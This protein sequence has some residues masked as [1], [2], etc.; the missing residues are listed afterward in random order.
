MRWLLATLFALTALLV[1]QAAVAEERILSFDSQVAIG[2]DGTLD[3]TET[4]HV[5]VENVAINHGIYRDFPTRY[6]APRGRRVKVGFTL[7][8]TLLDGQSEPNKVETLTN[9]VRIRIG[10]ADRIVPRG[11]HLYTIRYRA[12]RMIGRF[13]GYDELYWN[14]TGNDWNFPIDRATATITLPSPARF[15]QRAAYT[16]RQGSTEQAARVISEEPGS[17]RFITTRPLYPQEGLTVAAAFPKGVVAEPSESTRLG[18]FLSDWGPPLAGAAGL[19]GILG[20][21]F[22]AWRMAGRDPRPGTVV[23]LFSPPDDL[24]PAAMRYVLIQNLDNRGFAAALVDAAVK[25]HV[26]LV[27]EDGGWFGGDKRRIERFVY[28]ETQP[29]PATEQAFLNTLVSP[30]ESL[31]MEQKNH[32]TFSAA[33][34]ALG[35]R[36]GEAYEGKL[37]LRNYGWIGAAVVVIVAA[38]WLAAASVVI[39]EGAGNQLLVLLSAA[40]LGIAALIFHA[41]PNDKSTGRCLFHLVAVIV[42]GIGLVLALPVIPEAL[43]TGRWIPLA[44]PL[45]GLPFVLSSFFWMSAPTRE[46]RAVLD[47]IAGFKQ[48][49]SITERDRLDRMQ[50]PE[51][52]LQLFE[53]Y[54]PYAIALGVENRWADRYTGLLAAA[55]TAPVAS[56]GFGWYSGS[57]NPWDDTGGFVDSIGSSLASTISSASTAPGSSSGSGGGGSSGGGGGGGG[58]GGW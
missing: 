7:V 11:Q 20:Y 21:L 55:A 6:D 48:Y 36:F 22:Y 12:N 27:E 52:T 19:A 38:I 49:L 10:S 35:D 56:Q 58:G 37:F 2:T 5:R 41:A 13:D 43:K 18:W 14:V 45:V 24:S 39:S 9:G 1:P 17:I 23:P 47:R 31:L 8:E 28:G 53:R 26:R 50:A 40:A 54:L 30:N 44:I 4:I 33:K 32:A 57:H 16:G 15:G 25:G 3:V 42:G 34:K 29:L 51:D 46:G